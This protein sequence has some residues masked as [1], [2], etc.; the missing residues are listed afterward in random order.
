[1]WETYVSQVALL[2]V[3]MTLCIFVTGC[4][5]RKEV[6]PQSAETSLSSSES[7]DAFSEIDAEHF[8]HF[9]L[10]DNWISVPADRWEFTFSGNAGLMT[11]FQFPEDGADYVCDCWV[12][13]EG[14]LFL[15]NDEN[16]LQS[17]SNHRII[18][19]TREVLGWNNMYSPWITPENYADGPGLLEVVLRR[20]GQIVAYAVVHYY[21]GE[22]EGHIGPLWM[23]ELLEEYRFEGEEAALSEE[24]KEQKIHTAFSKWEEQYGLERMP[25]WI[26]FED[27]P[28][29]DHQSSETGPSE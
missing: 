19:K 8:A 13:G 15:D 9:S 3:S 5:R 12:T 1:M 21:T 6:L 22:V 11:E 28:S 4:E 16:F 26:P 29:E 23:Q 10:P 27:D 20:N 25:E 17:A 2:I 18:N 14:M 7:Q 24:E